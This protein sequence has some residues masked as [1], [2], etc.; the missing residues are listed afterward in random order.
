MELN[1]K[2]KTVIVAGDLILDKYVEGVVRRISPEAPVPVVELKREEYKPG[3]AANV[4][5]LLRHLGARVHLLGVIG[6]D[7]NGNLLL[8]LIQN[9]GVDTSLVVREE[10]RPTTVKTRVISRS[11][12]IVR[13]DKEVTR[14]VSTRTEQHV[15]KLLNR[16][17]SDADAILIE[18]YDKGFLTPNLIEFLKKSN[19]PLYVDPK[20]KNMAYYTGVRLLKPN[21][22]EF[23]DSSGYRNSI[24][25][26]EFYENAY[27]FRKIQRADILLITLGE[28]GMLMLEDGKILKI[29]TIKRDVYDVTGA[30][31]MVIAAFTMAD[32][33][34]YSSLDAALISSV[35]AGIEVT[36]MG[37]TP[38]SCDE[39]REALD[40]EYSSIKDKVEC[41]SC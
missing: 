30:G 35:A 40:E 6:D 16:Y 3:G 5:V 27:D 13:L 29:P 25:D 11:Q 24:D 14:P 34:G 41:I 8:S 36:K 23:M 21:L 18:D 10:K 20:I 15:I 39:I 1:F 31:D 2:T 38:V 33:S 26:V 12:H 9:E 7:E 32:L 19:L 22:R 37:A 28:R 17:I 4:A